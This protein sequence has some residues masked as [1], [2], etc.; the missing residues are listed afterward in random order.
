MQLLVFYVNYY[1]HPDEEAIRH[2]ASETG[3]LDM[4]IRGHLF[5]VLRPNVSVVGPTGCFLG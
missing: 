5:M 4:L 1:T 3:A 2:K